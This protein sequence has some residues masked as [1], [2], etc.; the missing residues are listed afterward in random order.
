MGVVDRVCITFS[1][2]DVEVLPL[3]LLCSPLIHTMDIGE[4]LVLRLQDIMV[5]HLTHFLYKMNPSKIVQI[6]CGGSGSRV[7][8]LLQGYHFA[9]LSSYH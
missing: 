1:K 4:W 6:S 5:L 9:T 8:V 2:S 3:E 7:G